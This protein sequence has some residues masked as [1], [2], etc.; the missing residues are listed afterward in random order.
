MYVSLWK[1]LPF[2]SRDDWNFSL[3]SSSSQFIFHHCYQ[4]NKF[5]LELTNIRWMER[6]RKFESQEGS[7]GQKD[8]T[9]GILLYCYNWRCRHNV[10][11]SNLSE[12]ITCP[13]WKSRSD[14]DERFPSTCPPQPDDCN[15]IAIR[16]LQRE[17]KLRISPKISVPLGPHNSFRCT[18]LLDIMSDLQ[19]DRWTDIWAFSLSVSH[20]SLICMFAFIQSIHRDG[21]RVVPNEI[22][23]F[24]PQSLDLLNLFTMLALKYAVLCQIW[25]QDYRMSRKCGFIELSL[26]VSWMKGTGE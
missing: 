10:R 16:L 9:T 7:Q 22:F 23:K 18:G 20:Q 21:W 25:R 5:W 8:K 17:R 14:S 13:T 11:N 19:S 6:S 26:R 2:L 1:L 12:E 15:A 24:Q 4:P 3:R